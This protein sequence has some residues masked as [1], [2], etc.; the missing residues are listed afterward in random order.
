MKDN[1]KEEDSSLFTDRSYSIFTEIFN[2]N[3]LVKRLDSTILS[4]SQ[5][6]LLSNLFFIV[7]NAYAKR[8]I[9]FD[10]EKSEFEKVSNVFFQTFK[11][12]DLDD[13][14]SLESAMER[15]IED[16]TKFEFYVPEDLSSSRK[17]YKQ[18]INEVLKYFEESL[19]TIREEEIIFW[20]RLF[21]EYK[22]D[23]EGY[24]LEFRTTATRFKKDL[25]RFSQ[26][27]KED[28]EN[29]FKSLK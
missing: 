2:S 6:K 28:I 20:E 3:G 27:T 13:Q 25:D 10:T 11:L 15:Y 16:L 21:E 12:D 14:D 23:K 5:V 9:S 22:K 7:K 19:R 26:I 24:N 8:N 1:T 29:T 17:L 4:Q 18:G